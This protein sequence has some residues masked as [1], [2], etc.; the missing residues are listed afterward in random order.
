MTEKEIELFF[1]SDISIYSSLY[2]FLNIND[3][4]L[5][6]DQSMLQMLRQFREKRNEA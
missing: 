5:I 3:L 6:P 1:L 4:L 2:F